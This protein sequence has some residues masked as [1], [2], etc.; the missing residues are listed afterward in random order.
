MDKV[1]NEFLRQFNMNTAT[2]W[3]FFFFEVDR[4]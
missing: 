2:M 4:P 1:K 3:S